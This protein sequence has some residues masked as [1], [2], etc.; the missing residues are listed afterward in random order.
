MRAGEAGEPSHTYNLR[1]RKAVKH[2]QWPDYP[3]EAKEGTTDF[4][5]EEL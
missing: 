2:V 4:D 1:P 5:L 3:A